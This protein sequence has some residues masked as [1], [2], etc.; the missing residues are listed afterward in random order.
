[1]AIKSNAFYFRY[2]GTTL[3]G[4][5]LGMTGTTTLFFR[6]DGSAESTGFNID[7]SVTCPKGKVAIF[8]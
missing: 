2:C 4:T 6:T 1:M 5:S 7:F 3:N 8:I